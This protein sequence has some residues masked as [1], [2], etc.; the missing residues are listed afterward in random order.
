M[1]EAMSAAVAGRARRALSKSP[2]R[3]AR[4]VRID[5]GADAPAGREE[6]A[7]LLAGLEGVIGAVGDLA[8]LK[9]VD[10]A[11]AVDE[12]GNA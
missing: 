9:D 3:L 8:A 4:L 1:L 10:P 5:S 2:D 7:G 12:G 11:P 6:V